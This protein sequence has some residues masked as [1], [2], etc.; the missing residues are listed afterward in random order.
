MNLEIIIVVL[1]F[2]FSILLLFKN[3]KVGLYVLLVLS[4]LLHKELFSIYIWDLMPIRVF[5]LGFL[6]FTLLKLLIWLWKRSPKD[7]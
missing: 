4:V 6:V 2:I 3:A 7:Y 1:L 5:M